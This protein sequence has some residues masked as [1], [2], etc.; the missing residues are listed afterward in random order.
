MSKRRL[1]GVALS[2]WPA[3]LPSPCV[4]RVVVRGP[5]FGENAYER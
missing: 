2:G 5:A 4:A 3:A 1:S